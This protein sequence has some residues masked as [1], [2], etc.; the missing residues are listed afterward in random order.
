[1]SWSTAMLKADQLMSKMSNI[2]KANV[3]SGVGWQVGKEYIRFCTIGLQKFIPF[4]STGK[5]VGNTYSVPSINMSGLCL[6]DSTTG[7]RFA[8]GASAFSAT[9]YVFH[10]SQYHTN[11]GHI[12]Y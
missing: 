8:T 10:S 6:Q 3:V 11:I 1:M 12:R 9:M 5:C 7:V 4:T 2:E